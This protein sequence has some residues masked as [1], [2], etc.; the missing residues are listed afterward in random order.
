MARQ[1][2]RESLWPLN[3]FSSQLLFFFPDGGVEGKGWEVMVWKDQ[4]LSIGGNK[5]GMG[6]MAFEQWPFGGN[7]GQSGQCMGCHPTKCGNFKMINM[8]FEHTSF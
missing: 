1:L 2:E 6:A 7:G 5:G 8:I 3:I 4:P